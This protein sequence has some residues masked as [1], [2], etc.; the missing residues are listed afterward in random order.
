MSS[1]EYTRW[2]EK[3]FLLVNAKQKHDSEP[4]HI[5]SGFNGSLRQEFSLYQ[6][7]GDRKG[8]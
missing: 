1:R 8:I 5:I 7:E 4:I 2:S 6:R 3:L